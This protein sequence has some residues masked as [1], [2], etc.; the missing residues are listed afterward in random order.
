M[1]R[2]CGLVLVENDGENGLCPAGVL[3]RLRGEKHALLRGGVVVGAV[4]GGCRRGGFGLVA[5]P[6]EEE[7][8]AV[9]WTVELLG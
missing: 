9:D 5:G 6:F 4:L 2:W 8:Y 1:V 3:D 7:D